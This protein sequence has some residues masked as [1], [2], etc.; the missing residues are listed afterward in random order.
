M[1]LQSQNLQTKL[2][3]Y[4][5]LIPISHVLQIYKRTINLLV[6][7]IVKRERNNPREIKANR[8]SQ[9]AFD[10]WIYLRVRILSIENS[11]SSTVKRE[12][13]KNTA[14]E[15]EI[16]IVPRQENPRSREGGVRRR[17]WSWWYDQSWRSA[18]ERLKSPWHLIDLDRDPE[19]LVRVTRWPEIIARVSH[20]SENVITFDNCS[21]FLP[22]LPPK[23]ADYRSIAP[24]IDLN[25]DR[26]MKKKE[27][28]RTCLN[29]KLYPI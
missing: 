14:N 2:K 6:I 3:L 29:K 23:E 19:K 13:R 10:W 9:V 22:P 7:L 27:N 11:F 16:V 21:A 18:F 26:I 1:Y 15:H 17:R 20:K 4:R 12:L 28:V 25:R 8:I 5:L 24:I